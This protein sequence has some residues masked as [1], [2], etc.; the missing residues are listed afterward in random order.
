[1]HGRAHR[2]ADW[3]LTVLSLGEQGTRLR[4]KRKRGIRQGATLSFE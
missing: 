3:T 4:R 1:M 2:C